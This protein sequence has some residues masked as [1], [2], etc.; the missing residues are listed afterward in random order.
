MTESRANPVRILRAEDRG[1]VF[2]SRERLA[3]QKPG[4]VL[5][6]LTLRLGVRG[7]CGRHL[8]M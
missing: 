3:Q 4:A 5:G 1:P 7:K 2:V 6:C 8:G